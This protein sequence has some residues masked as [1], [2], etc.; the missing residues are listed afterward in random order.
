MSTLNKVLLFALVV[1]VATAFLSRGYYHPDEH[2]QI[3]EFANYKLG[4]IRPDQ[5]PWEFKD[6]MR[7]S[8]MPWIAYGVMTIVGNPF[9]TATI[10]RIVTALMSILA[11]TFFIRVNDRTISPE[12][13]TVYYFLS[14]LLWFLPFIN[15]RFSSESW[16]GIFMLVTLSVLMQGDKRYWVAGLFAGLAFICRFQSGIFI[17]GI[18][19]WLLFVEKRRVFSFGAA[20]LSVLVFEV[21]IDFLFY[22]RLELTF[23]NYFKINIVDNVVAR[24]GTMT[25][26]AYLV[27][28]VYYSIFP[29]GLLLF[30]SLL[31]LLVFYPRSLVTWTVLPFIVFHFIEPHKELRFLFPVANL[32]PI[33]LV[34]SYQAVI[35]ELQPQV[36]LTWV[37]LALVVVN[38]MGLVSAMGVAPSDGRIA[39]IEYIHDNYKKG[40]PGYR[41]LPNDNPFKPYPFLEQSFYA[42]PGLP[43]S[44]VDS[45]KALD[46]GTY[47]ILKRHE[48]DSDSLVRKMGPVSV[49]YS[50]TPA[51]VRGM[52]SLYFLFPPND[53]YIVITKK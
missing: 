27:Q 53:D 10:L 50:G 51:F 4:K 48:L 34:W 25:W 47:L 24:F 41:Y 38:A 16:S 15:V 7:P 9:W 29:I 14:F 30:L 21:L 11:I 49:V 43:L 45:T 6:A 28:T 2:F 32:M 22:H 19:A 3:L 52:Q 26:Y 44:E 36:K 37:G 40:G 1:Y 46:R 12:H 18:L 17:G 5:L 31:V 42:V 33:I 35:Q 20:L 39:L 13:K 23:I 8:F